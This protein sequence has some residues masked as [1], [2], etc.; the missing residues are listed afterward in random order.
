MHDDDDPTDILK[1]R[2]IRLAHKGEYRK[3]ALALRERAA[4]VNDAPAWV[5]VGYLLRRARRPD[6]GV[7][8]RRTGSANPPP[9]AARRRARSVARMITSLD[10]TDRAALKMAG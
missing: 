8:G 9:A 10:P 7:F 5:M 2:A 1:R 3:A 4:L 6:V